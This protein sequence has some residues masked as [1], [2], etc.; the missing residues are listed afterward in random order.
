MAGPKITMV[1]RRLPGTYEYWI[2]LGDDA[3]A[4][5]ATV[6]LKD[7]AGRVVRRWASSATQGSWHV[8]DVDGRDGRVTAFD[9]S[10][11]ATLAG[12]AHDQSTH[13]CPDSLPGP[14]S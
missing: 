13:V 9:A 12:G 6:A 5:E 14:R 2:E 3:A 8:F 10:I 11:D 7:G 1:H 4:G